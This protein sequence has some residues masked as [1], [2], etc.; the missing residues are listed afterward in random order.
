M[1]RASV[2]SHQ[3]HEIVFIDFG[4]AKEAD[5][6]CAIEEAIP[7]IRTKPLGSVLTLTDASDVG[8]SKL[9][10]RRIAGSGL[11]STSPHPRPLGIALPANP[12]SGCIP[13]R[14]RPASRSGTGA[15]PVENWGCLA[16]AVLPFGDKS[17]GA[18]AELG[19]ASYH[20]GCSQRA[21]RAT[22]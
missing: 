22:T 16:P 3:G 10:N 11:S 13:P 9:G 6:A 15:P 7:L 8:I 12:S 4:A 18:E 19:V 14:S 5:L 20:C 1:S 21:G 2:I 17:L